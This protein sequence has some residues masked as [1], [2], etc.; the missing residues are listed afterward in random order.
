MVPSRAL[1]MS[2]N[3]PGPETAD[4]PP[5][6]Y[7]VTRKMPYDGLVKEVFIDIPD[8]PKG[9]AGFSVWDGE[10]GRK[11]YPYD[12]ESEYA[13]FNNVQDWWDITFPMREGEE[14]EVRYIN[15]NHEVDGHHLKVWPVVVGIDAL[16]FTLE[17]Y[18]QRPGVEL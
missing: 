6:T 4:D 18:A 14:I 8:G 5:T 1:N 9:R 11:M 12:D 7:T 17:D 3:I 15:D 2:V 10:N 13:A 16:P